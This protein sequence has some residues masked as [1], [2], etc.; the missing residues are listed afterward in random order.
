MSMTLRIRD[1]R[2]CGR[3]VGKPDR[4]LCARCHWAASHAP[5][6]Q[7]CPRCGIDRVLQ[8]DTG[9]CVR[10]SRTC[11]ICDAPVLFVARDLCKECLRRQ[12]RDADRAECPRCGKRRDLRSDTGY[13]GSCSR[14]GRPPNPDTTCVDC[15]R[16]ARLTGAGRCRPCWERSPHRITVRAANLAEA[17]VDPPSWLGGFAANLV[18]RHHPSRA[19]AMLTRLGKHLID[20]AP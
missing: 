8:P 11:R 7:P 15:G 20:D 17:L 2:R 18:G 14:P 12:R 3:G 16:V 5:V 19:C 13:C 10:C 4:D 6:E 1:C 9:R